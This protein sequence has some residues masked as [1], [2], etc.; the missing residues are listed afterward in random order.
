[1]A[2]NQKMVERR[3]FWVLPLLVEN[4]EGLRVCNALSAETERNSEKFSG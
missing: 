4:T 2:S 1:M 3:R